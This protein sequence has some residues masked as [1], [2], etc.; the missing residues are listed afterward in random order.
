MEEG[1]STNYNKILSNEELFVL[2]TKLADL[3][4]HYAVYSASLA[5]LLANFSSEERKPLQR[6]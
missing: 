3:S 1:N 4:S 6:Q 2:R 5:A